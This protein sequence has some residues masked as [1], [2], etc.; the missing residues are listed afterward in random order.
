MESSEE[1]IKRIVIAV[2]GTG[3]HIFPA[4]ALAE[5]FLQSNERVKVRFIGAKLSSNTYFS[6]ERFDFREI[7]SGTPFSKHPWKVIKAFASLFTGIYQSFKH[8]KAYRPNLVVGF[9]SFHSFPVLFAARIR[10]TPIVLFESNVL[11]GKVNRLC[12]KWAKATAVQF[13]AA[14]KFL[15]GKVVP[16]LMPRN[17]CTSTPTRKESWKYYGLCENLFTILIVGGSQGSEAINH[18]FCGAIARLTETEIPFQVIHISGNAQRAEKLR[19]VYKQYQ[20]PA[21]VKPFEE[22]MDYAWRAADMSISRAGSATLAEQIEFCTP[23]ILIPFP[24][25]SEDH[26]G[27]NAS[28]LQEEVKG[29][30]KISEAEL[31]SDLLFETINSFL[32]ESKSQLK[33]MRKGLSDYKGHSDKTTLSGVVFDLLNR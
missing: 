31:S 9:G 25:A 30:V 28:F 3:G 8:L 32:K 24:R 17:H 18:N 23:G 21:S 2:G 16:V 10:K 20:I 5:D 4:H 11:P 19:E 27:V 12:S 13:L 29:G 14:G 26:Q 15:K 33:E 22:R 6:Q 7:K 1:N